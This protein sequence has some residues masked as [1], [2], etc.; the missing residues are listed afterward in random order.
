MNDKICRNCGREINDRHG[1]CA[2]C[3]DLVKIERLKI[4]VRSVRDEILYPLASSDNKFSTKA[5]DFIKMIKKP[6]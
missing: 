4:F 5:E 3:V 2:A 6:I 1:D